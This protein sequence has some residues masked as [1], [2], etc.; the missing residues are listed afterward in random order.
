MTGLSSPAPVKG[1]RRRRSTYRKGGNAMN[2]MKSTGGKKRTRR[3]RSRSR[4]NR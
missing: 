3:R 1:G 2:P 4:K